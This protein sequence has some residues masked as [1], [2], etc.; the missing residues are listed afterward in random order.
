MAFC[1]VM[2]IFTIIQP[3]RFLLLVFLTT[4]SFAAPAERTVLFFGDSITAG[5]GVEPDEAYPALIQKKIAARK[6]PVR[7]MNAGLS[8]DTTAAGVERLR[9]AL[10]QKVDVLVL[11]LGGNDGLRG[12]PPETT[13]E[14][15]QKMIDLARATQPGITILVAGM[16]M[17]PNYG[18]SFTDRF[19]R[20]FPELAKR[21]QIVLIPF[22]LEGVGGVSKLNL[23][24]RI[25]PTAEG[26]KII[27]ENIWK[28][29]EGVLAPPQEK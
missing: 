12:I 10:R 28:T 1:W 11:A 3:M 16:K 15:L 20:I 4:T 7:T 26:H 25:H 14:N 27:A 23:P 6:W 24:D 22:L 18:K 19:A 9:W 17:P 29:L 8:G 5:F 21:N 13:K 2:R